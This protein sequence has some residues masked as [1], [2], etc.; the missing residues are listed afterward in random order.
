VLC[1]PAYQAAETKPSCL[2]LEASMA[3][4]E[5]ARSVTAAMT[6]NGSRRDMLEKEGKWT[7]KRREGEYISPRA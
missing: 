4:A 6:V 2:R 7:V 5:P 3:R 1:H